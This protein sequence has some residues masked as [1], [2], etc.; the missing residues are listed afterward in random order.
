M[1]RGNNPGSAWA[2]SLTLGWEWEL[3]KLS[4][5][6]VTEWGWEPGMQTLPFQLGGAVNPCHSYLSPGSWGW[7]SQVFPKQAAEDKAQ[8]QGGPWEG[9]PG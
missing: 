6:P 1:A 3:L 8:G 4:P 5:A 2:G 7:L 9:A